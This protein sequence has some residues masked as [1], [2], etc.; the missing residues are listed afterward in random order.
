M[1][2]L[3]QV[4]TFMKGWHLDSYAGIG[5]LTWKNDIPIPIIGECSCKSFLSN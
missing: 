1:R 5:A 2:P 4:Q 3:K